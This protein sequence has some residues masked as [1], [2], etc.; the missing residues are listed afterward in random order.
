MLQFQYH[1]IRTARDGINVLDAERR[2]QGI[3]QMRI[4]ELADNPDVG[5]SYARMFRSGDVKMSKYLRFLRAT[6]YELIMIKK[7]ELDE[8]KQGV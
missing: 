7:G 5:Q 4:A 8:E 1:V 2:K 6:G 3:S